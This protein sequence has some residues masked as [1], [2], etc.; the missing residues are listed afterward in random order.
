M[1]GLIRRF[2]LKLAQGVVL[3]EAGAAIIFFG[4]LINHPKLSEQAS[5]ALQELQSRGY[6]VPTPLNPIKVYPRETTGSFSG[7]HAGGWAPGFIY[8]REK[9][10]G[11]FGP[12]IY[13][14][15]ELM[16]EAEYRT[17][18][19]LMP[20]WASE[21]AAIHFSGELSGVALA[22]PPI[23]EELDYLRKRLRSLASLDAKNYK[24]ISQLVAAYGWPASPCS[25][26]ED[27]QQL[28]DVRGGSKEADFSYI[29][30]HLMSGRTL[31][32][33]GDPETRYP[34]GSLLKISYATALN[35][36]QAEAIGAELAASNSAGLLKRKG[37]F[38]LDTFRL[39]ISPVKDSPLARRLTPDELT[40]K[41]ERFWRLFLGERDYDGT[42]PF[43]ANLKELAL[44]LRSSIL[45]R[46]GFFFGLSKNGFVEGSTL[47]PEPPEE[48][49]ILKTLQ[50]MLKTGT[51]ADE[52]GSPM[53][54]HLMVAWPAEDPSYL[55]VFRSIG[56][57]GASN[58]KRASRV[59]EG[60]SHD[61]PV[62]FARIRVRIMSLTP[63]SSWEPIDECPYFERDDPRGWKEKV[64]ICGSFRI[65]S[66]ARG[67]RTE[68]SVSGIL[69]SSSDGQKVVL[70]TDPESYADGV[71]EAEAQELSGEALKALRA[72]IV[73][74][75]AHGRGR[76]PESLSLCDSTHCMVFQGNPHRKMGNRR[77]R[78]DP[79]LLKLL[80]K[81]AGEKG[82]DWL[83][84]SKGGDETWQRFI[85]TTEL[86][87]TVKES[88]ILDIRR[89]R[90]KRGDVV[91][92]LIYP[93]N[94]E[95]VPCEIFRNKLKLLSCPQDIRFDENR[96]GFLFQGVGEGHGQGL[97][98]ERAKLLSERGFT[99][100]EI[101][102]DAYKSL[103]DRE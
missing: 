4:S 9:P 91:V 12:E 80:D 28:L 37:H 97:S 22:D 73:W 99:A 32:A 11:S 71:I 42:F 58:I 86:T 95:I 78:T 88:A 57:I 70:E 21:A 20:E 50:A 39:M 19:G 27:I 10:Q 102:S 85:P 54:G 2:F 40:G 48:K 23:R 13:L 52:R 84:F 15:H 68:R 103:R 34:P 87:R 67:S 79:D 66:S 65:L 49:V 75:G 3:F 56:R 30:I 14:R 69:S 51:V 25:L 8:L 7:F 33:S 41:D 72:V 101:L 47:Y 60:W 55:A 36:T 96:N 6:D 53:V 64:S 59:L 45:F 83:S 76:H 92:H 44:V 24:V 16:H 61:Y 90:T 100:A 38:D 89:E 46:P 93:E 98:M 17:C 63:R 35:D 81:M 94:E 82:L 18:L 74:N 29:L 1:Y 26:S 31:E 62:Q 77:N 43:E 5:K